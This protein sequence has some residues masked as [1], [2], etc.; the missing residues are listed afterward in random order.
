MS[1]EDQIREQ[2]ERARLLAELAALEARLQQAIRENE[3]LRVDLEES[4]RAAIASIGL[5]AG[6]QATFMPEL[7]IAAEKVDLVS[8]SLEEVRQAVIDLANKYTIIKNI[9]TATKNLTQCDDE[10]QRKFRLYE[11]FRKVCIGYVIGVDKVIISNETLRTTLEKNY[12]A[13]SDYWVAHCIMATMLWV[14]DEPEAANRAIKEAMSIDPG[15]STL[16]FLLVNLRFGRIEAAKKW[17]NLYMQNIDVNDIHDEWQYLLE[18]YLYKAFGHDPEFEQ[19]INEEYLELIEEAKKY[20]INYEKEV[21]NRVMRFAS[22]YPHKTKLEYELLRKY[23]KD[24]EVLET[25]LSFAEKNV[26]LAKF[27]NEILEADSKPSTQLYIRIENVLYDLINAY[28]AEEL[29]IINKIKYNEYVIKARGDLRQASQMYQE[30]MG[31]NEEQ[32]LLDLLFKFAFAD[33]NSN[34]DIK[35]RQFAIRF[36]LDPIKKGYLEYRNAYQNEL[37]IEK[38]RFEVDGCEFSVNENTVNEARHEIVEHYKSIRSANIGKD[39]KHKAYLT[40]WILSLIATV[41]TMIIAIVRTTN[42]VNVQG[43]LVLW[44]LLVVFMALTV[45][46][47]ILQ[48][49]RRSFLLGR[50]K[51]RERS[52]LLKLNEIIEEL[53][54]F[55][56]DYKQ[57]D[58]QY[59]MIQ[60]TLENFRKC[61]D[62]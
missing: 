41:I 4:Q 46:F 3:I 58:E 7:N 17:Y 18:A 23:C 55:H 27:Y 20:M 13:N 5:A 1:Y 9:S 44:I 10:Y 12:L 34:I 62:E 25:L 57:A 49:K 59:V 45:L 48:V 51:E 8:A 11:K 36:L 15:K 6:L 22:V 56:Q 26:E 54:K 39:K 28:D 32:T 31:K 19:Q 21:V 61:G 43:N 60:E 14:S 38:P 16:F 40:T 2:Q 42:G 53:T 33:L 47:V 35:V 30:Q 29:V 50:L 24:Y 52:T 37:E